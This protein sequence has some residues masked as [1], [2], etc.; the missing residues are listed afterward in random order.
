LS[1]TALADLPM[2]STDDLLRVQYEMAD[3]EIQLTHDRAWVLTSHYSDQDEFHRLDHGQDIAMCKVS[4]QP[5]ISVAKLPT[6]LQFQDVVRRVLG[7]SFGE[8]TDTS[9]SQSAAHLRIVRVSVKGKD[10]DVPARWIY[11]HVSDPE[12]RQVTLA[13]RVEERNLEAFGH[14][15][16]S[17]AQSLQFVEKVEKK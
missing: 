2:K 8:I 9:E 1:E 10:A 11:Y 17:L 4:P 6:A 15:D 3:G 5:Q 7:A 13:F 16:E 14:A 12:G